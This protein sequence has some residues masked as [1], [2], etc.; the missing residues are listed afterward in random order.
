MR[1]ALRIE[2]LRTTAEL[3]GFA[4]GWRALWE[5]DPQA[6]PFQHPAWL[7]PWWRQ[8]AQPELRA[9][10]LS[11]RSQPI[12]LLPLYIYPDPASGER[13]LLPLGVGTSDYLDGVFHPEC[14]AGDIRRAVHALAEEDGWDALDVPQLRAGSRLGAALG[15]I[16]GAQPFTATPCWRM[17]AV[18]ISELPTKLRRNV[19]YYRNR[20]ARL[21]T[22]SLEFADSATLPAMFDDLVR[23]HTERWHQAGEPGA[24]ADP[25][26]VA[27]H[28]EAVPQ[29]HAGGLLRL[30]ALL[31]NGEVLASMYALADPASRPGSQQPAEP[32][33]RAQYVYILAYSTEHAEIGPGTVLLGMAMEHAAQEGIGTIDM[34][35]GDEGYK[36]LWHMTPT[37]TEGYRLLH[38]ERAAVAA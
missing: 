37:A 32:H 8:F 2:F 33:E 28:R 30:C 12:G 18:P 19:M 22:L 13:K 9:V 15:G 6:T 5:A 25:R 11:R 38:P 27:W 14:T 24:F 1:D 3:E 36:R 4:A 31:R 34:L 16:Q 10:V 7:A 26:M 29:L 35:R 21:G 17:P 23:L 20:A